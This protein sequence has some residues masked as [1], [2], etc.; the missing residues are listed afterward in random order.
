MYVCEFLFAGNLGKFATALNLNSGHLY[1]S[2]YASSRVTA[3]MLAQIVARTNVR[4]EWLLTGAGP[5]FVTDANRVETSFVLPTELQ[6]VFPVFD[7]AVTGTPVKK[8]KTKA[9]RRVFPNNSIGAAR[10]IHRCRM[11]GQPVV[12]FLGADALAKPKVQYA[13]HTIFDRGYCTSVAMTS[14]CVPHEFTAEF[15]ASF[16][17]R[18]AALHGVGL[19]EGLSRWVETEK[20]VTSFF[21]HPDSFKK[22]ITVHAELGESVLH[23]RPALRGAEMG[24]AW[25]AA[26]YVDHLVFAEQVRQFSENRGGV[27]LL[28]G[29]PT[30]GLKLLL[31]A[32]EA[33]R[34][35]VTEKQLVDFT[36]IQI[37]GNCKDIQDVVKSQGGQFYAIQGTYAAAV[38]K[39]LRACDDVYDGN[40][41]HD[42]K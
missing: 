26:A 4:A 40:I 17:V 21:A 25:G 27:F 6:S 38:T 42:T 39:L 18:S 30:R 24:A 41:P 33:I 23:F 1:M 20:K 28:L 5:M 2:L 37:G 19:G 36:V 29:E 34:A 10:A 3:N 12:F 32:V 35:A 31:T 16:A 9:A 7:E 11:S 13:A 22:P 14:G 8:K 15:D